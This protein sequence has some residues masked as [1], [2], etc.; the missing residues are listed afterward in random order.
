[1]CEP[2]RARFL[3][4]PAEHAVLNAFRKFLMTPGKML[5]FSGSDLEAF[6]VPLASLANNGLLVAE[7]FRGGYALTKAGF[8]AMKGS[9]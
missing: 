3:F 1:M 2:N 6:S 7:R 4:S 8:A 9:A 5:C